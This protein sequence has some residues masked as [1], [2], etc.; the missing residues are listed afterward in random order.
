MWLSTSKRFP[1]YQLIF[2]DEK[3]A[4]VEVLFAKIFAIIS[5]LSLALFLI[6]VIEQIVY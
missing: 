2:R 6:Q 4:L 3:D 1:L 5:I